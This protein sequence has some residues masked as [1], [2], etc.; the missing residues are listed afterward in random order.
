MHTENSSMER[1][2][3]L[4]REILHKIQF[5]LFQLE[6]W[7]LVPVCEVA[8]DDARDGEHDD[9]AGARQDLVLPT[10]ARVAPDTP[11][12]SLALRLQHWFE[13]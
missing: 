5:V 4:G 9:E 10:L 13:D 11:S 8:H 7:S 3:S 12:H 6:H 2:S 1:H